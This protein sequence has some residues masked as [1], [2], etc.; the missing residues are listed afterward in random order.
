M[1]LS[2]LHQN[3]L[4]LGRSP[5][6][7]VVDMINGFTDPACP[8]GSNCPEVVA[9]NIELLTAFRDRALPIFFTSVVYHNDQQAHAFTIA[10]SDPRH[11]DWGV[12]SLLLMA[13]AMGFKSPP[14]DA[15]T[16]KIGKSVSAELIRGATGYLE[17]NEQFGKT[18]QSAKS[19]ATPKPAED[20][21]IK[22]GPSEADLDAMGT[23]VASE[24]DAP[25]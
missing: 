14:T 1:A 10:S 23:T 9:A 20:D 19:G 13:K 6:L 11:V 25:F 5:A 18:W 2:N 17:I 15:E 24:D 12:K 16:Q 21:N 4:G 8:L 7:L 22:T 3:Q